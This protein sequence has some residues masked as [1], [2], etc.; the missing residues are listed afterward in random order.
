VP[1]IGPLEVLEVDDVGI[2]EDDDETPDAVV[3]G[4]SVRTA[5]VSTITADQTTNQV[6][7]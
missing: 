5:T 6:I 4:H 7:D 2:E 3:E 1:V